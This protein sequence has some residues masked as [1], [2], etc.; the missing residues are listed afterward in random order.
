MNLREYRAKEQSQLKQSGVD[1]SFESYVK[2]NSGSETIQHY[3]TK[4][5]CAY[6]MEQNGWI[7]N[8]EVEIEQEPNDP[9]PKECDLVCWGNM[10][11][12][13]WIIEI[14]R[15]AKQEVL[16]QKLDVYVKQ[17]N[18]SDMT[19]IH[20]GEIPDNL[21]DALGAIEQQLPIQL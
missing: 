20:P 8:S 6:I 19:V 15:N 4:S 2:P 17:T 13:S 10:G 7:V 11:R 18:V 21:Q 5:I 3:I 1:V 9:N 12:N 16:D 14:E